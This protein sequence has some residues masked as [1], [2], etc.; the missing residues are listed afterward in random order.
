MAVVLIIGSLI[1][2]CVFLICMF[3]GYS[4]LSSVVNAY[5]AGSV[6]VFLVALLAELR[7]PIR[8]KPPSDGLTSAPSLGR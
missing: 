2:W 5:A 4:L 7:R 6:L 3:S 1:G 8:H